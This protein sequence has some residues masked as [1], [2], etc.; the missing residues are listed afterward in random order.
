[1]KPQTK[2]KKKSGAKKYIAKIFRNKENWCQAYIIERSP[3]PINK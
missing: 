3:C 1:M 2:I